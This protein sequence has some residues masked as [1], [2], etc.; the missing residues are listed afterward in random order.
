VLQ[1]ELGQLE[2]RLEITS[3]KLDSGESHFIL[4]QYL[5]Q[6]ISHL[7]T[8]ITGTDKLQK[9]IEVCNKLISLASKSVEQ[10]QECG[11]QISSRDSLHL[12]PWMSCIYLQPRVMWK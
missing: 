4:A 7:L 5:G 2:S 10:A 9:Q 11:A 3:S 12:F 1:K 6:S 8:R